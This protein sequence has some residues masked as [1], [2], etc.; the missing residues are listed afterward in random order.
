M[1]AR[2]PPRITR[3]ERTAIAVASALALAACASPAS[4]DRM[5]DFAP[6]RPGICDEDPTRCDDEGHAWVDL[7]PEAEPRTLVFVIDAFSLPPPDANGRVPGLDLDGR[8]SGMGTDDPETPCGEARAD[9]VSSI[10]PV[11]GV[12]NQIATLVPTIEGLLD[13]TSCT[14]GVTAGCLDQMLEDDITTGRLLLLIE[15]LGVNS[16]ANDPSISIAVHHG[17]LRRGATIELGAAG[18]LAANQ[19]FEAVSLLGQGS[20]TILDGRAAVELDS[21][22]LD[23]RADD[24]HLLLNLEPARM[25]FDLTETALERGVLAGVHYYE[26]PEATVCS[27]IGSVADFGEASDECDGE[28]TGVSVGMTLSAVAAAIQDR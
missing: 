20:G 15:V 22:P 9:F 28:C 14:G 4:T 5:V 25:R 17:S 10:E 27:V 1:P 24:F 8:E 26:R 16:L 11:R 6:L 19:E 2:S 12:D 21:F 7:P 3:T 13:P 23:L 18:R